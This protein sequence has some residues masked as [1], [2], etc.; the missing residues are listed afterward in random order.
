MAKERKLE[1]KERI[2]NGEK[3]YEDLWTQSKKRYE[4]IPFVQKLLTAVNKTQITKNNITSLEN[5]S[6]RLTKEYEAKKELL[7]KLDR[8]RIVK[9][10]EFLVHDLPYSVKILQEKSIF[11]N[12]ISSEIE[13]LLKDHKTSLIKPNALISTMKKELVL[14]ENKSE[15]PVDDCWVNIYPNNDRDVL[16]VSRGFYKANYNL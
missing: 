3:K 10:A 7:A 9:L 6:Q 4:S 5:Q 15:R 16:M 8:E 11:I 13:E 12:K 2:T 14:E 1:I